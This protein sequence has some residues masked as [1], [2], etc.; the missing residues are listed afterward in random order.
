[1]SRNGKTPSA[2]C[3]MHRHKTD[4]FKHSQTSSHTHSHAEVVCLGQTTFHRMKCT[5]W[6]SLW[7][8]LMNI[9]HFWFADIHGV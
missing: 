4:T 8:V 5:G 6:S 1:M 3:Y 7:L 9:L 2:T